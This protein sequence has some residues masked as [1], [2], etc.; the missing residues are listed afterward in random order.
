MNAEASAD[1][2]VL[3]AEKRVNRGIARVH[4][5]RFHEALDAFDLALELAPG[6]L[7]A[8]SQAAQASANG[9]G[10]LPRA[11]DYLSRLLAA[12]PPGDRRSVEVG[13]ALA[14]LG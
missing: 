10:D 2:A 1:L 12:L 13:R 4:E 3:G 11:R 7:E 14:T 5:R 6:H 9:V 8:L